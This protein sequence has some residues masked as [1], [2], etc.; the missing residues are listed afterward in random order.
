MFSQALKV[1]QFAMYCE[2]LAS[3]MPQTPRKLHDFG[4]AEDTGN[5]TWDL[6]HQRADPHQ[7]SYT[8]NFPPVLFLF[9]LF[10]PSCPTWQAL[11][12][13]FPYYRRKSLTTEGNPLLQKGTPLL[14]KNISYYRK[15]T[16]YYYRNSKGK[17]CS[18]GFLYVVRPLTIGGNPLLYTK[19]FPS[20]VCLEISWGRFP[21]VVRGFPSMVSD[22]LELCPYQ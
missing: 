5:R 14:Q 16:P 7:L 12:A 21:S 15:E 19:G 20:I 4:G 3:Y 17:S 22:F 1:I 9:L 11:C 2:H 8:R 10:S 6:L 13:R 18:K